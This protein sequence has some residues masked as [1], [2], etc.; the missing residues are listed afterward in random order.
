MLR[1]QPVD[2]IVGHLLR[3]S[4][5]IQIAVPADGAAIRAL[6]TQSALPVEGL[7]SAAL[8]LWVA[9]DGDRVLG[10]VGLE[11]YGAA[12]LLRSLVVAATD[13]RRGL[14][15]ELVAAVERESRAAGVQLLVLLTQTAEQFFRRLGYDVVDRAY[16][17]DEVRQSAEFRSLCPAS[18]ACMTKSLHSTQT[19]SRND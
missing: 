2:G 16:V 9:R 17:P 12:G 11:R 6:L 19:G 10:A 13:Q 18:A 3:V 1:S 5:R 14:G 4:V 15:Q 7:E 8:R